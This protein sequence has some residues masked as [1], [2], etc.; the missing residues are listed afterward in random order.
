MMST[1]L[2]DWWLPQRTS[3]FARFC[4]TRSPAS[5]AAGISGVELE[6]IIEHEEKRLSSVYETIDRSR[7]DRGREI[8]RHDARTKELEKE[9][10]EAL[11]WKEKNSVTE[12]L[13]EHG[14]YDP[15]RYLIEFEQKNSPYFGVLG[16]EDSNKRIGSKTYLIGKQMLM[17]GNRVAIVD[18]R[19]A[20]ISQLFY[21]F[22]EGEEYDAEIQGVDRE[23]V[24]SLKTKVG[25]DRSELHR[26]ERPSQVFELR[27]GEWRESGSAVASSSETK[28]QQSD[29]RMVDIVSLISATQFGM[30][31]KESAGCTYLTGSAGTGKTT[32]A[33]HR[34]SYLQFA[35]PELFRK[36]RSLVLMFNRT[37]RDY[38][39]KTS[40]ELL[41]STRVD[42]FSAWSLTALSALGVTVKTSLDDRFGPFKKN[43]QLSRLL[44]QHV[45][46]TKKM[47]PVVDLWRFYTRPCVLDALFAA[48]REREAFQGE[49]GRKIEAK[50]RTVSFADVTLLVRLCQLRR[51]PDSVVS[52]AFNFY[53]HIVIDEAQD[54]GQLELEAI[55][56]ACS[57]RK[58]LTVCADEKQK[59]LSFVDS[60]GFANFKAALHSLGLDKENLALSYRSAREIMELAAKVSG[61]PVDT[62]KAHPGAA[63]F[64]EVRDSTSAAAKLRALVAEFASADPQALTAVIC[65]R[66]ADIKPIHA[67]LTGVAGLHGDGTISFEPGVLVVNTHQVKGLEFTNV[68]LWDP[69]EADYRETELDRN[70]LYVAITRAC[71][72]IDIIHWRPLATWFR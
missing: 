18:W 13:V 10:L 11:G 39:K 20:E 35:Q 62:S 64:H 42:T 1:P 41:G 65:K 52:G 14:H 30:I 56:A 36:E 58:S 2:H 28:S 44:E 49:I 71:K 15:R 19:R 21:D 9:R 69:N 59:I 68:V 40:S 31:T 48:G 38:V 51:K 25:I 22:E 72:R 37:L 5:G 34:L 17:D 6:I 50:D 12:K 43:S 54:F 26:I 7:A 33:L 60:D 47:D 55:L 46:E 16:I 67:A 53:D 45:H 4:N 8:A 66:K 29:H 57:D 23:G 70:L 63:E 61:R 24:I 3:L 32:V 27:G